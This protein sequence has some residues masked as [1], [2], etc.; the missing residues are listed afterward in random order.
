M[1]DI[2]AHSLAIMVTLA[3]GAAL[4]VK[5][6]P[7]RAEATMRQVSVTG[8]QALN[9]TRR[10]LG[11]LRAD[12]GDLDRQPQPG[13]AQIDGLLERVRAT[14]MAAEFTVSGAPVALSSGAEVAVY[15]IVQEALTNTLKHAQQP[16]RV[17]VGLHYQTSTMTVEV[18]DDGA[19]PGHGEVRS[20]V[21]HGLTG[22]RERAAVY[23]G[24]VVAGLGR[25]GG[26]RVSV[27]LPIV[28]VRR[29]DEVDTSPEW[30]PGD[31]P[32]SPVPAPAALS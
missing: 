14:G 2:V 4:K 5:V 11:V 17:R 28:A 23:G 30:A 15:R 26:W 3:E 32:S 12:E 29:D 25:H 8:R 13:V 19:D 16:T 6:D 22:M 1:H 31:Q 21:G 20:A 24:A 7:D 27:D 18:A 10:L 9:E